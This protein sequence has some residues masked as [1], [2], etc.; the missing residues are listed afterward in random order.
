LVI[1]AKA[2]PAHLGENLERI[3]NDSWLERITQ[4]A[5]TAS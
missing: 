2:V 3:V 5:S 1:D 4:N